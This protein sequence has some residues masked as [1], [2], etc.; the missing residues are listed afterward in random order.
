[1]AGAIAVNS[2]NCKIPQLLLKRE[3]QLTTALEKRVSQLDKQV[4]P[5]EPGEQSGELE[6]SE[7]HAAPSEATVP[8]EK[9]LCALG[10][11]MGGVAG[12][13]QEQMD[14]VDGA[15][16][17]KDLAADEAEEAEPPAQAVDVPTEVF[18]FMKEHAAAEYAEQFCSVLGVTR[19]SDF[20][21]LEVRAAPVPVAPVRKLLTADAPARAGRRL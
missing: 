21:D 18:E 4:E 12:D 5:G 2:V 11:G 1:M 14:E 6:Q 9:G 8:L 20:L 10:G 16:A 17:A 7:L 13:A 19:V 15:V 3:R